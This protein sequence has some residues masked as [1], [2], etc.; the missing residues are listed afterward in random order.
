M[1]KIFLTVV[2][3]VCFRIHA[4][5]VLVEC[6]S[7]AEKGGW[8]VDTLSVCSMGS[9]YL[10]AHGMGM[11]VSDAVTTHEFPTAGTWRV[12]VRTRD[13][14]PDYSGVKPGRF[15][16][17][18]D[19]AAQPGELGIAPDDW[20][21]VDAGLF[22]NTQM[23]VELR[24]QDLTGF[25]GRCDAIYFCGDI[26][27][28]APPSGG[29]ELAA[30]R[31]A[32]NGETAVPAV[33]EHSDFVVVGGG[34]AGTCAAMAA[35]E[36]GMSVV[37]IQDRPVLGG[38]ASSEIR[39]K[40]EG[41]KRHRIVSAVANDAVNGSA[42][43][44]TYDT[45]RMQA[46]A[47]QTNITCY[48]GWRATNVE[49]SPAGTLQAVYAR[50]VQSGERKRFESTLFADCTG[51]G[52]L[53]FWGGAE[54]FMGR[55]AKSAYGESRA[56]DAADEMTMGNTLMWNTTDTGSPVSFP[57]VP[58]AMSVA[59]TRAATSGGWNW[60]YGMHLDTI[61]DAEQIRDHLLRA[62]YGNF[63]NAKQNPAN[64]N[65]AF[66]WVPYV[67]GK[68]ESRRIVGD[69][70]LTQQDVQEGRWFEDA[71]GSAT[72]GIDLHYTTS[73]SYL[74]GYTS[75]RVDRWFF[76][77][78][79]LYSRD[80]PNLFM[81]GRNISVTHVGLGSP[82]V[83][84][85]CGQM[86]VAVG[87]AAWLCKKY[88]C[89]PRDIYRSEARTQELQ[90][91]IGG[92]WPERVYV[93]PEDPSLDVESLVVDNAE[94]EVSGTWISST[95]NT[96]D[97][98]GTDY[99]HSGEA[100]SQDLWVKYV[101]DFPEA[102]TCLLRQM[103]N[104]GND[105][106]AN[107]ARVEIA[108]ADGTEEVTVDMTQNPGVWN[109]LGIYR[110]AAGTDG[111]ARLLT[112]GSS[113]KY[114]IADAFRWDDRGDIIIDNADA[115]GVEISGGWVES[116]QNSA[117]FGSNILHNNLLSGEDVWVRFTP[118]ISTGRLY[119]VKLYW[120][121]DPA[122]EPH[123]PVEIVHTGGTSVVSVDMTAN[124]GQWNTLGTYTFDEGTNGHVRIC[125]AGTTG[126]II[127]DAVWFEPGS[128]TTQSIT[129]WDG[130]GLDDNWERWYFL[131]AGGVDPEG[132]PDDDGLTNLGEFIAG[133]DP[134]DRDSVFSIRGM[135][136]GD[137][138]SAPGSRAIELSWP[139]IE[140]RTYTVKWST[141]VQGPYDVLQT[142]IPANPPMNT[143]DV[144]TPLPSGFFKVIAEY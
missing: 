41:E 70:L 139:S 5:D 43:S 90:L 89:A 96:G 118:N 39:V 141:S 15:R 87:Y 57:E 122:N 144:E 25:D 29:T 102:K 105:T 130:N 85:T 74:S 106:R 68:R 82:R 136:S 92:T 66:A 98:Y 19:G 119:E 44:I 51:D 93:E 46:V 69:Y 62:I 129:D 76:P 67:T 79:C 138:P 123:V 120:D 124:G 80:I 54:F 83:M 20:A 9:P 111:W 31:T 100:A 65:R 33:T 133:C 94:A 42:S 114:V 97:F 126:S 6:E 28:A 23:S 107:A 17:L 91:T 84:N 121:A 14:T 47:E 22:T 134:L 103:W 56:P 77:Y 117:R 143:Y 45:R 113:G 61:Y 26:D 27:A 108:H 16:L 125:T 73:V 11:P 59:G 64:A 81:A 30:W 35:A 135:L 112:E 95:Y 52:W 104:G 50:N 109:N 72:W 37:L 48:T 32:V 7:F 86:G 8:V 142:G 110:F 3:C 140:G 137:M 36:K 131:N 18:L 4:A 78:R 60:E 58:W 49:M 40:T 127:A 10:L 38:N 128:T 55:E 88:D 34:I 115:E 12:W 75:T 1:K 101:P 2:L 21:W 99:L 132:D 53:G 13:W 116:S 63:Y 71:V 24:L